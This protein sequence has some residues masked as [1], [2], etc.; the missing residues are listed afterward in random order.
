MT[1][2]TNGTSQ[3]PIWKSL[4]SRLKSEMT[5]NS[6][7]TRVP[8][9]RFATLAAQANVPIDPKPH[10]A[11]QGVVAP[12]RL[13]GHAPGLAD[14]RLGHPSLLERLPDRLA[15]DAVLTGR[16]HPP[17]GSR[18]L[19]RSRLQGQDRD[20][21]AR[22]PVGSSRFKSGGLPDRRVALTSDSSSAWGFQSRPVGKSGWFR[23]E[24]I[25][26]QVSQTTGALD[27]APLPGT[28]FTALTA[29]GNS[30]PWI[31]GVCANRP[32]G[33]VTRLAPTGPDATGPRS[34]NH[35]MVG[36][37][38]GEDGGPRPRG[39]TRSGTSTGR[40]T[41]RHY[42]WQALAVIIH[43]SYHLVLPARRVEHVS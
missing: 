21:R 20:E 27:P 14:P 17:N 4:P 36:E 38:P 7:N 37:T 8:A 34:R 6:T 23:R 19:P 33:S 9:I 25:T 3:S 18:S 10:R 15:E 1:A 16:W 11:A 22:S 5:H 30:R 43:A 42:P 31:Q 41:R 35:G 24:T 39:R 29:H 26:G 13:D 40:R 12:L 28:R 32:V 2:V